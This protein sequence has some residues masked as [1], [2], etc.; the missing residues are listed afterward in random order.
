MPKTSATETPTLL[1]AAA[2][3]RYGLRQ[4]LRFSEQAARRQGLTPQQHQLL[5]GIAGFT[6]RGEASISELSEF[7][8]ERH[9][10]T[11]GLVQR[12]ERLGLVKKQGDARDRRKVIVNLTP[13][14]R[15]LLLRLTFEHGN[16]LLR[17]QRDLA[18]LKLPP[19]AAKS[20]TDES[21]T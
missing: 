15:L 7:L 20:D 1:R 17:L 18:G 9:N 10:A 21:M 4:F 11:V 14:G 5:L 2:K 16:E 19:P 8:Q 12:A 6:G 3:F 13:R